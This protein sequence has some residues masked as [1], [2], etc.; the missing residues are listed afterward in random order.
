MAP[1][2]AAMAPAP[3][4]GR[5]SRA[6]QV[7]TA[8]P[9]RIRATACGD[10]VGLVGRERQRVP[11]VDLA[12]AAR[13]RAALAVDHERR[14]AVRPALVDVGAARLF[15]H[16]HEAEVV[17]RRPELAVP[18]ADADGH[19]HP[20]RLALPDVEAVLGRHAGLA[21]T[22]QQRAL[23]R[24][25][26]IHQMQGGGPR[27]DV[28]PLHLPRRRKQRRPAPPS[29]STTS[30]TD[31]S[32]PSAAS[33]VTPRSAIPH[34]TMWSNIERSVVTLMAT[35]CRVRRRPGPTRLARTPMAAILRGRSPVG[36]DPHARELALA[37]APGQSEVCECVDDE[38]LE[39]VHVRRARRHVVGHRDDR[40]R[41]E[42]AGAV[43]GHVAAA[44]GALERRRR[45]LPGRRGRGGRRRGRPACRRAG[46]AG[47]GGSRP[48]PRGP[49]RAAAR[50]PRGTGPSRGT[51]CA[52]PACPSELGGPVAGAEE[53]G[54][55]RQE[56]RDV[57]AVDRPVVPA[58][59]EDAG[60]VDR[61]G[62][63][64][65]G[66]GRPRPDGARCRRSPG[67]PPAAG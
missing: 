25:D 65:V 34:G 2:V 45:P 13:P 53:L 60:R 26:A 44:V 49:G 61:D 35:P 9:S 23:D 38:A 10:T 64:P 40:V 7:T 62:L 8:C 43:V 22:P 41:H 30:S 55:L 3:P 59:A 12:E 1:I 67:S 52:A 50:W 27:H 29:A 17:D 5:S 15:A 16:R 56:Q 54:H 42:L 31:T 14:G 57:G 37:G 39:P 28:D 32:M 24:A 11:G 48:R 19:A 33:D 46:A 36:A 20:L 51:G 6:T 58:D 47:A 66:L 18:L 4:S 63:G 21:Q